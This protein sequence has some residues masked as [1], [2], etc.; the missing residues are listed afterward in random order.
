MKLNISHNTD[1]ISK[2]STCSFHDCRAEDR[3][4][5]DKRA[6]VIGL[7]QDDEY[8]LARRVSVEDEALKH[9][10]HGLQR[11]PGYMLK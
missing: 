10:K 3:F 11:C 4:L 5:G 7:Q 2:V 6:E 1:L 9:T 8:D